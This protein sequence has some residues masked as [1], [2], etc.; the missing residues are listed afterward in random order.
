MI[1]ACAGFIG[2]SAAITKISSEILPSPTI[3]TAEI[4]NL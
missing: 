2:I 4:L 3:L 1:G